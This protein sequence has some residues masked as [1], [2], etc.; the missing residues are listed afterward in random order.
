MHII[1]IS[2]SVA[3]PS[4]PVHNDVGVDV[5]SDERRALQPVGQ[6]KGAKPKCQHFFPM[7]I[8]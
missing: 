4:V 2:V 7:S 3:N 8:E 5:A 1:I 6:Q